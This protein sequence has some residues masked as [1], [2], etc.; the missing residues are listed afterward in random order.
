[1]FKKIKLS[2]VGSAVLTLIAIAIIA[3]KPL[4]GNISDTG[5]IMLGGIIITLSIWI[6]KPFNLPYAV[7]G[8]FLA[9]F[10]L[11]LGGVNPASGLTSATIFSGFTHSATWTLIPALFFGFVLAKTGLGKRIAMAIIKIFKP[12]YASLVFAWVII[13]V[14]LSLLTPA[15]TVRVAIVIPIAMQCCELCKL[16]K[17]SKGNSLIMLTAFSMALIPGA[18]WLTGVVWG[19]FVQGTYERIP[20]LVGMVTFNSWFSIMF[21]PTIITAVLLVASSLIFLKPKEKISEEAAKAIRSQKSD[22]MS[23]HE[24]I[25]AVVLAAIFGFFVTSS[26][27]GLSSAVICLSAMFLFFLLGV[28][29]AKDFNTGVNW[30]MI[31]FLAMALSLGTILDTTGISIWIADIIV[32]ALAPIA[33]NPWIF[34]LVIMTVMFL[35]R[36]VDVAMFLPTISIVVPILP[37]IQAQYGIH[38]LVWI[39]VFM[40]AGNAFFMHYQNVWAMMSKGMAGERIWTNKHLAIYGTLY[41]VACMIA[42]VAAI[43]IWTNAGL[44]G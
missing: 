13:G 14:V 40:L 27:H 38:P 20:E 16:E 26:I 3:L 43:P 25:A 22:R 30:D 32:P 35:F 10:A 8:L 37:A 11:A 42:L 21:V 44:F 5:Q 7:G 4:S 36:F 34:M 6:F 15:T 29:E 9:L 24:I 33:A 12:S 18:A 17:G 28:L 2:Y 1:M 23:T 19:P 31:I 41:F 39:A